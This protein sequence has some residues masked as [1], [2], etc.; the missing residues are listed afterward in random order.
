M[1][2]AKKQV[3]VRLTETHLDILED[4]K[5]NKVGINSDAEAI[6]YA[7]SSLAAQTDTENVLRKIN[8]MSKDISILIEMN[9]GG[10]HKLGVKAI[11]SLEESYVYQDAKKH[12]ENKIQHSTT[13]KSNMKKVNLTNDE[14]DETTNKKA[15]KNF[16]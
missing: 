7:I 8:S 9:A 10:F 11:G 3:H 2:C 4:L 16:Y 14:K 5:K 12:V 15:M 13:I 1:G 6:R